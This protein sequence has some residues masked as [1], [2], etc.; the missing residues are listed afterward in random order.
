[1][2]TRTVSSDAELQANVSLLSL[3]GT[4]VEVAVD[5]VV[6]ATLSIKGV[7]TYLRSTPGER[8]T[9]M[10]G[11]HRQILSVMLSTVVISNLTFM[12]AWTSGRGG[13]IYAYDT[14]ISLRGVTFMNFS[15]TV[16]GGGLF[17][18]HGTLQIEDSN[19]SESKAG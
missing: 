3:D 6:S 17:V 7:T 14:V 16:R 5:V 10:S 9:L 15:A 18:D 4:V 2:V 13:G 8:F 12:H 1:M 11:N 19:F